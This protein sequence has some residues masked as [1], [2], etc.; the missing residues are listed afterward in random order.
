M[1]RQHV[2]QPGRPVSAPRGQP[3]GWAGFRSPGGVRESLWAGRGDAR[4]EDRPVPLS[5]ALLP[6]GSVLGSRQDCAS[7][8]FHPTGRR[9]RA[10]RASADVGSCPMTLDPPATTPRPSR[11]G[12]PWMEVSWDLLHRRAGAGART[13]SLRHT[14]GIPLVS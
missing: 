6:L 4:L 14:L 3:N 7:A 8:G 11:Q 5:S 1:V 9:G 10:P 13:S 12:F 2:G